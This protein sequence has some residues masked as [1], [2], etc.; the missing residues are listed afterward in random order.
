MLVTLLDADV[1][2]VC[3][4]GPSSVEVSDPQAAVA[5]HVVDRQFV[6]ADQSTGAADLLR[7]CQAAELADPARGWTPAQ[8]LAYRRAEQPASLLVAGHG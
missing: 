4:T 8:V 3:A 6:P 5:L 7:R 2:F 1:P